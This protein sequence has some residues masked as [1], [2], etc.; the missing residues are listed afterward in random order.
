MGDKGKKGGE[1]ETKDNKTE[2]KNEE[3]NWSEAESRKAG[4]EWKDSNQQKRFSSLRA[5][6]DDFSA[7]K[8]HL[9]HKTLNFTTV[10]PGIITSI[11]MNKKSPWAK[12]YV[13]IGKNIFGYYISKN[14]E[15]ITKIKLWDIVHVRAKRIGLEGQPIFFHRPE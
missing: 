6:I 3:G 2:E 12:V 13:H 4:E 9:T 10:Y 14:N 5:K 1:G 7:D 11:V 8:W 15:D